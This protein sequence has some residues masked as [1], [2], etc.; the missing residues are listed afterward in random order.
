M[1]VPRN[2]S[3]T[4]LQPDA[5]AALSNRYPMK[6]WGGAGSSFMVNA[7][8]THQKEAIDFLRWL[9]GPDQQAALSKETLNLPA[10]KSSVGQLPPLLAANSA[11]QMDATSRTHP[12]SP[13]AEARR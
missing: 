12:N 13:V 4:K 9:T 6:I 5:A 11:S 8:S 7:R 1:C 3:P 10:N 2:E